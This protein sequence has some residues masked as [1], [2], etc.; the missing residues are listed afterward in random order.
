M[1]KTLVSLLFLCSF[2]V[3]SQTNI[4]TMFYNLLNYSTETV[5]QEKTPHLET[6]LRN[7]QPDL[8]MVCELETEEASNYL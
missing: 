2:G 5:S 7:K 1:K 3:H 6:I 8:F 4:K